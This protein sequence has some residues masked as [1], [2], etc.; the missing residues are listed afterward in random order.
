M[1]S[2]YLL[3]DI[4]NSQQVSKPKATQLGKPTVS[5][6]PDALAISSQLAPWIFMSSS[7]ESA[8]QSF[9]SEAGVRGLFTL[10][11]D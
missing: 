1:A 3:N 8:L 6:A 11:I 10:P 2:I 9:E 4:V 5:V 7:L